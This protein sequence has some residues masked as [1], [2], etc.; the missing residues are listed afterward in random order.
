MNGNRHTTGKRIA[1]WLTWAV[2]T[3]HL[4][5]L[6]LLLGIRLTNNAASEFGWRVVFVVLP[7][8]IAVVLRW[9]VLPR[10]GSTL[11]AYF[12]SLAGLI[13]ADMSGLMMLFLEPPYRAAL[14]WLCVI[15][16]LQFI[17]LFIL[18]GMHPPGSPADG[19]AAGILS[20]LTKL[21]HL[22]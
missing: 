21:R 16:M 12:V 20:G 13:L 3:G 19:G 14:Y 18:K 4:V 17:P 1:W 6:P 22:R 15:G 9:L 5:L 2:L 8:A 7:L 10:I 11:L